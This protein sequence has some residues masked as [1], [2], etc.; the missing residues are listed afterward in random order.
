MVI[1]RFLE[2][3]YHLQRKKNKFREQLR[4][5]NLLD[6]SRRLPAK[7]EYLLPCLDDATQMTGFDHH[8]I[9]HPAWAARI[10]RKNNPRKHIDISSTLSFSSMLSAFV[11]T[12]FYDFR[13]ADLLLSELTCGQADLTNLFFESGSI[14]SLSCMHTVEHVG[15]GRYG[16]PLD[17]GGDLKAIQELKRVTAKE[18]HLLFVIPVGKPRLQFNAHRIYSYEMIRDY[19]DGFELLDFSLIMDSGKFV[20]NADPGLVREQNYGCGCFWL[21]NS[22]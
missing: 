13:P 15:L 18:G 1:R 21:K 20:N 7:P 5:F 6:M 2:A 22:K 11:P 4:Q 16:D 17:P 19:F 3:K 14:D 8:Y 9:Y 10:I 12:E